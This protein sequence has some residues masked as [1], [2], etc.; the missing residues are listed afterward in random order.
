VRLRTKFRLPDLQSRVDA[1][2]LNQPGIQQENVITTPGEPLDESAAYF[3]EATSGQGRAGPRGGKFPFDLIQED[4]MALR[5]ITL[6]AE[7]L[8]QVEV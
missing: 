3:L 7:L 8:S 5:K 1:P 4:L 2:T 6:G